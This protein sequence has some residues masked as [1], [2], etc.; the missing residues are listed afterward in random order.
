MS[1]PPY[2]LRP[3][4]AVDRFV[5]IEIL[6]RLEQFSNLSEY[7]YHGLGGPYLEDF[8]VLYQECGEIDMVSIEKNSEVFKRQEFHRPFSGVS[9]KNIDVFDFVDDY[10]SNGKKS[11]FWLDFTDLEFRNIEYFQLL[12]TKVSEESIVKVTL[13]AHAGDYL[14]KPGDFLQKFDGLLPAGSRKVPHKQ[15]EY[16]SLIQGMVKVAAGQTMRTFPGN[17]FQPIASF[18][19]ADT[20]G[21]LT[22]TGILCS[23]AASPGIRQAFQDW[24]FANLDWSPPKIIDVPVLST[25][26]RLFLED[27]L[28]CDEPAGETLLRELGYRIAGTREGTRTQLEQYANFHRHYPHFIRAVP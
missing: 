19:Y 18:F 7:T 8:R 9:L 6:R 13:R 1:S 25:K 4:K 27:K 20:V 21:I 15:A 23:V 3:N 28:P 16:A 24:E 17:K 11:I 12:L 10:E 14:Q 5:M 22:V 2:H 26:E